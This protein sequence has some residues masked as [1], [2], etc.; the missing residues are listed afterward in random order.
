M[1]YEAEDKGILRKVTTEALQRVGAT[2]T[3]GNSY[4]TVGCADQG[5][6]R[7]A[8]Q[9]AEIFGRESSG[10]AQRNYYNLECAIRRRLSQV[11][12]ET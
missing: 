11:S 4:L 5:E 6:L 8:L 2:I 3:R 12:D 1:D 7:M 10:A 9:G